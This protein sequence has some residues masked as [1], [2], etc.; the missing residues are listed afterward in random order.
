MPRLVTEKLPP[1]WLFVPAKRQ[2]RELLAEGGM[3]GRLAEFG[4]TGYGRR[5]DRLSLGFLESAVA[6]GGWCFCLRV[7]GV[8]EC[9]A[10][11]WREELA[12]AALAEIEGYTRVCLGQPPAEVTKPAQLSLSFR[13]GPE[14]VR[15][16]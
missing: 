8:R 14:G 15:S 2:V 1:H 7:W 12:R 6:E 4:G 5:A 13:L 11:A 16:E 3:D 10:G 9:A